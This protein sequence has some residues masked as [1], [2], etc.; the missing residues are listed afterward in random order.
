MP[1][2]SESRIRRTLRRQTA[3][4]RVICEASAARHH[5]THQGRCL[6]QLWRVHPGPDP[7]RRQPHPYTPPPCQPTRRSPTTSSHRAMP[8]DVPLRALERWWR[9][10]QSCHG[11]TITRRQL[12]WVTPVCGS[13]ATAART[14]R[15]TTATSEDENGQQARSHANGTPI[16][17][18]CGRQPHQAFEPFMRFP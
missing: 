1:T 9:A 17:P 15:R 14:T 2:R 10:R 12:Q 3:R 5:L 4:T 11:Q 16:E 8:N 7:T 6:P 18:G 13:V